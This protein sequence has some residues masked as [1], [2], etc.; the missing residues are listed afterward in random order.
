MKKM[1]KIISVFLCLVSL[2]SCFSC[3]E[4][5]VTPVETSDNVIHYVEGTLHKVNVTESNVPFVVNGQTE[6]KIYA[7]NSDATLSSAINKSVSFVCEQI[8]NATG[9][10]LLVSEEKP[11]SLTEQTYAIIYGHR[12]LL[13]QFGLSMPT[14]DIGTSGYYIKISLP[15]TSL[16]RRL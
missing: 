4:E 6:Y 11:Q 12:D 10:E 13:S 3:K 14:E 1:K 8:M 16:G 5:E 15:P 2:F 7:D 9:A